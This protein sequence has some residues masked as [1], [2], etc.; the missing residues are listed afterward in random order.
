MENNTYIFYRKI[1]NKYFLPKFEDKNKKLPIF[2]K[3][4]IQ[5]WEE[6]ADCNPLTMENVLVQSIRYNRKI[7]VNE[8][9]ITWK[10]ASDLFVQNFYDENGRKMEWGVFK[11]MNGKNES[12]FLNGVRFQML[13]RKNGKI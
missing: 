11:Q 7:L 2:Y 9:V 13:F 4:V 6:M 10:E 1:F 8:N 12:F 3:N 5:E